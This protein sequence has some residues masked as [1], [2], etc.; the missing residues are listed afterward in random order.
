M[1]S[2]R[3][4]IDIEDFMNKYPHI[5]V[6]AIFTATEVEISFHPNPHPSNTPIGSPPAIFNF[7]N[8]K[9][10]LQSSSYPFTQPK[11]TIKDRAYMDFLITYSPKV[12]NIIQKQIPCLCCASILKSEKWMPTYQLTNIIKEIES[13]NRLKTK[14]KDALALTEIAKKYRLPSALKYAVLEYIHPEPKEPVP[15]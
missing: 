6:R 15:P 3:I 13:I 9:M 14:V 8:I 2:K 5:Q 11:V 7:A 1:I 10:Y 12:L 4:C